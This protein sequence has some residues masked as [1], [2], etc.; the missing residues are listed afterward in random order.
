MPVDFETLKQ[1]A[2]EPSPERRRELLQAIATA[3]FA[4]PQRTATEINLFDEIMDK[5]LAE[6]ERLAELTDAPQ[7]TLL[8]LAGDVIDVAEPVLS[9]SPALRDEHLEPIARTHS[10]G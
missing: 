7:R 3:F 10:Q 9:H 4:A 6:V 2:R 5:V 1:L 8:R